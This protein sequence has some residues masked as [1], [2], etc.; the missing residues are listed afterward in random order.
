[1]NTPMLRCANSSLPYEVQTDAAETGIGALLQQ[2]NDN[3]RRHVSFISR[4]L[5]AAEQGV[6]RDTILHD[7]H[8][9]AVSGHRGFY[10]ILS[11]IRCS[12]I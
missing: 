7:H 10:K 9:A 3:G 4:K 12:F 8:D 6:L 11:S 2:K 1:M 5:N